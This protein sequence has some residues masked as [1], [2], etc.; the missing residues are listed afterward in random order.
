MIQIKRLKEPKKG[1]SGTELAPGKTLEVAGFSIKN[2]N[3]FPVFISSWKRP[4][5]DLVNRKKLSKEATAKR[6]KK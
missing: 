6:N 5:Q 4:G 2:K 1:I 3:K